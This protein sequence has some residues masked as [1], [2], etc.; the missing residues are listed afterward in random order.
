M[1]FFGKI[2]AIVN[3]SLVL[4][5]AD[6]KYDSHFF[7]GRKVNVFAVFGNEQLSDLGLSELYAPKGTL[8]VVTP[9][10]DSFF[11]AERFKQGEKV[12][13]RPLGLAGLGQEVRSGGTWSARLDSTKNRKLGFDLEV[14]VGDLVGDV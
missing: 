4:I 10:G 12:E 13:H 2:A 3:D 11:L 14:K 9:Q 5:K 7:V 8:R 6:P 1:K